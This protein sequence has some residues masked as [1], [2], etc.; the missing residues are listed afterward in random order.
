MTIDECIID[1]CCCNKVKF[2]KEK[3]TTIVTLLLEGKSYREIGK[4]TNLLAGSVGHIKNTFQKRYG[5]EFPQTQK[6]KAENTHR[7]VGYK[8][9]LRNEEDILA[10]IETNQTVV[11]SSLKQYVADSLNTSYEEASHLFNKYMNEYCEPKHNIEPKKDKKGFEN[12]IRDSKHSKE[13]ILSVIE[14]VELGHKRKDISKAL[15]LTPSELEA[16]IYRTRELGYLKKVKMG[17]PSIKIKGV[18]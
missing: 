11:I 9:E 7:N 18:V 3:L 12:Y 6:K 15:N 13:T 4:E 1:Y 5:I 14:Y 8:V 17:R 2:S 10:L 16:I